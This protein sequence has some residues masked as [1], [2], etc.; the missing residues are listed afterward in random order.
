MGRGG[1][2]GYSQ[3]QRGG[4]PISKSLVSLFIFIDLLILKYCML[5]FLAQQDAQRQHLQ[6]GD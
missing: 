6:A 5:W 4:Q 2:G 1:I 3:T